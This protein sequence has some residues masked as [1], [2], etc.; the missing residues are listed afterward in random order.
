V[1]YASL[2]LTFTVA[3][4]LSTAQRVES[5]ARLNIR[6]APE[7]YSK[8]CASC[9]GKD[10]QAKTFKAKFNHARNLTDAT[11]HNEVSD[12]RIFNS[13]MNGRGKKMPAY[14]KKFSE[15]EINSLA[16]FVRA[17]KR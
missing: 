15:Q 2:T 13:I 17:L 9:H 5:L 10:G 11:W 1:K 14:G 16:S 12:E 3:V 8:N 6:T 7:L 4:L